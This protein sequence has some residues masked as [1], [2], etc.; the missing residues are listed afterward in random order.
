M[1]RGGNKH[2]P[3]SQRAWVTPDGVRA[4]PVVTAMLSADHRASDGHRGALLLAEIRDLLQEPQALD[5][6]QGT[7]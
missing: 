2:L 7:S 4:Q 1:G 3:I 5:L 6:A